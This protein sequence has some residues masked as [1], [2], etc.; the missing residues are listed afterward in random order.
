MQRIPALTAENAVP[1]S[2]LIFE[3]IEK[4]MGMIPNMVRTMGNS[5]SVLKGYLA[6]SEALQGSTIDPALAA[7]I[8]ITVANINA[9]KYC[10]ASA[11][12]IGA[13]FSGLDLPAVEKAKSGHAT[14]PRADAVLTFVTNLVEKRGSLTEEDFRAIRKAG[15]DDRAIAEVIASASLAVFTNYFCISLN[16]TVDFPVLMASG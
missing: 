3:E 14:D 7:Q 9:C 8:A 2:K 16:I 15:L 12:Y 10:D 13:N 4:K 1:E 6:F 5:P 11:C